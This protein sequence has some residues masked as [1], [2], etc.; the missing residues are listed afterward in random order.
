VRKKGKKRKG[1]SAESGHESRKKSK[2][3]TA[4]STVRVAVTDAIE[5]RKRRASESLSEESPGKKSRSSQEHAE[6]PSEEPEDPVEIPEEEAPKKRGRP[7][8]ATAK[9]GGKGKK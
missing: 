3:D 6:E 9:R 1:D 4:E 8:G 5:S 2:G 7:K